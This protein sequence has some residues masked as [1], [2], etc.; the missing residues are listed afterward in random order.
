MLEIY[1]WISYRDTQLSH[2]HSRTYPYRHFTLS[3]RLLRLKYVKW[4]HPLDPL[5]RLSIDTPTACLGHTRINS[6]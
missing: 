2:R 5:Y 1:Q 3:I 4:V 6:T